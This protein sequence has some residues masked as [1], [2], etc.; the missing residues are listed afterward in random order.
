LRLLLIPLRTSV[1]DVEARAALNLFA[2][3]LRK[4][5]IRGKFGQSLLVARE[6]SLPSVGTTKREICWSI[7]LG[8]CRK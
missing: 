1:F 2:S 8:H 4:P 6:P 7:V 5:K 3:K